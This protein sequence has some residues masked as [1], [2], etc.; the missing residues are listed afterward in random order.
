MRILLSTYGSRGDVQ[1]L[2]ALALA[3]RARGVEALVSTPTDPEFVALL[4]RFDVRMEPAFMPVRDWIAWARMSGLKIPGFA[5]RMVPE[6]FAAIRAAAEGCDAILATGLF[7]SV[8]A[9]RIVAETMDLPFGMVSFSPTNLPSP[10]HPPVARPGWPHPPGV[11]DNTALWAFD[12]EAMDG[13]FAEAVNAQRTALGLPAIE[14][15]RDHV[16]GRSAWLATDPVLGPWR[17]DS[18]HAPIQTGAWLLA[19]DRALPD[20]VTAFLESGPAP[21]HVGFGSMP[22]QGADTGRIAVEAVRRQGRRLILARGWAELA[23]VEGEDC[24]LIG[25]VDQQ[26]LFPRMAAVVHHGGAGTTTIATR[27]GVPQVIVPQLV[28][29]PYWGR[30]VESLG[31]GVAHV[32]AKPSVDSLSE[33]LSIALAPAMGEAAGRV[34]RTIRDDGAA[35]A[36]ARLIERVRSGR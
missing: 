32:G 14:G 33:A 34:G 22:M 26:A 11:T 17:N 15:V 18:L 7:P 30:R 3:L 36:A 16:F 1:P 28:D 9:A 13:L 4:D 25:E 24:L 23:A 8:A 5:A 20:E 19:D 12:A 2:A 10:D 35:I 27:A 31:V 29:Q 21:V 6:Q